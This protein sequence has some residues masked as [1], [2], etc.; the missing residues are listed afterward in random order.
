MTVS[1]RCRKS[2]H[3]ECRGRAQLE[4]D[5]PKLPG[6]KT[7]PCA[8]KKCDHGQRELA[9]EVEGNPA[10]WCVY[11]RRGKPSLQF[12]H[13]VAWQ[14]QIQ[15][16]A[17]VAWG[18]RPLLTGDVWLGI[19][20]YDPKAHRHD[21]DNLQKAFSDALQGIIYKNDVQVVAG[22]TAKKPHPVGLTVGWIR[23]L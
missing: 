6:Q 1:Y 13:M 7:V 4:Q 21:R 3:A 16:A 18:S 12:Q 15:A 14:A 9:F 17:K 19:V 8:C 23:E 5:G 2:Q 20:F 22:E 10:P 11:T